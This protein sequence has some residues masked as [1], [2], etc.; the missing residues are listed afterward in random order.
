MAAVGIVSQVSGGSGF[1]PFVGTPTPANMPDPRTRAW[2]GWAAAYFDYILAQ[3]PVVRATPIYVSA[4]GS[5]AANGLTPATAVATLDKANQLI[6]ATSGNYTVYLRRGDVWR[7]VPTGTAPNK[8]LRGL[9]FSKANGSVTSYTD[10]TV[11]GTSRNRKPII[12]TF[13]KIPYTAWTLDGTL[14]NSYR[15][16]TIA[17]L[18]GPT[19]S[20]A[21]FR[22]C[23]DVDDERIYV[24]RNSAAAVEANPGSYYY[25]A[26]IGRLWMRPHLNGQAG[27]SSF[28]SGWEYEAEYPRSDFR[29]TTVP[30]QTGADILPGIYWDDLA[31]IRVDD[32]RVDGWKNCYNDDA[33]Y[34][35]AQGIAGNGTGTNWSVVTNSECYYSG[36][37]MF[38]K[39][40]N[41][42]G[43]GG[44]FACFSCRAGMSFENQS[45]PARQAQDMFMSY[46]ANGGNIG[47]FVDCEG[48]AA[49]LPTET[50]ND[51]AKQ[52]EF[53]RC[54]TDGVAGHEPA[55]MIAYKC[56]VKP[57]IWQPSGFGTFSN[58][59]DWL[60]ANDMSAC[61]AFK[62]FCDFPV[63]PRHLLDD[64][65]WSGSGNITFQT[66]WDS[67][68]FVIWIGCNITT[69][70]V[71]NS[72]SSPGPF[73]GPS[74]MTLVNCKWEVDFGYCKADVL[75]LALSGA[76]KGRFYYSHIRMTHSG[77]S[78]GSTA[79][80]SLGNAGSGAA[81]T[82]A[83]SAQG[84]IAK[85]TIFEI[86]GGIEV[87]DKV[88]SGLGNN[89]D[90]GGSI[91]AAGS[92]REHSNAFVGGFTD[93]GLTTNFFGFCNV[94]QVVIASE[95]SQYPTTASALVIASAPTI[96]GKTL[97]YDMMG[98]TRN[99]A[100]PT[101][102]PVQASSFVNRFATIGRP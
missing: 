8:Y 23:L 63:R 78:G 97:E 13:I 75:G 85:G 54:H 80:W 92:E 58:M 20:V 9:Y 6:A 36:Q 68:G 49:R 99:P 76:T 28:T 102:G 50:Y 38:M 67:A 53:I 87:D 1:L 19:N 46:T 37:H 79:Q 47:V 39:Q 12:T 10:E 41:A 94:P 98:S 91:L 100:V 16:D 71:R 93:K 56:R 35:S 30:N 83:K 44:Y 18:S 64:T 73:N 31:S 96:E 90:S 5:D 66:Q 3:C 33:S 86:V 34:A 52:G 42:G 95:A 11:T 51:F 72:T 48:T 61:R 40:G 2:F 81:D 29:T 70:T 21:A 14:T 84:L 89:L 26:S 55:L 65:W 4:G 69:K 7:I 15:T 57:G 59:P 60:V 82:W 62:V 17:A 22:E 43:T 74:W 88:Y 27:T 24:R 25:D 45:S 101:I 77:H 32:V